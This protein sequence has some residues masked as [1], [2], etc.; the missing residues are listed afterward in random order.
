[1]KAHT[2]QT[3]M[4]AIRLYTKESKSLLW[5]SKELNISYTSLRTWLKR[6]ESQGARGLRP[7]YEACGR[8]RK[9]S[10]AIIQRATPYKKQHEDWGAGFILLKLEDDFPGQSLPGARRIEDKKPYSLCYDKSQQVVAKLFAQN[11]AG[12]SYMD[13]SNMSKN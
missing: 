3:R 12:A 10:Q 7:R 2:Q 8:S 11:I 6:Y 13:L 5:I 9:F 1:M 4:E